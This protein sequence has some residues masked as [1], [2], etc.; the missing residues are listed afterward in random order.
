[1][2]NYIT[3]LFLLMAALAFSQ[4]TVQYQEDNTTTGNDSLFIRRGTV[5]LTDGSFTR[6]RKMTLLADSASYTSIHKQMYQ[7]SLKEVHSVTRTTSKTGVG[8]AIGAGTGLVLGIA[9]AKAFGD[10]VDDLLYFFTFGS[11]EDTD[12]R[13]E[14][15]EVV[16]VTTLMGAGL[17]AL[18]GALI[19]QEKMVY[20]GG[21]RLGF[22]VG[23]SPVPGDGPY[24]VLA[25]RIRL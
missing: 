4:E 11:E 15:T 1:M 12:T 2:K 9:G 22:S 3:L 18:T 23:S 6:F 16:I 8:L 10:M 19:R 13:K 21:V 7:V 17:G 20:T 25:V 14:E 5:R 24:P